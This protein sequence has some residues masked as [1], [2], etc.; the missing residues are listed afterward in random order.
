[1]VLQTWI[2]FSGSRSVRVSEF[3]EPLFYTFLEKWLQIKW[4]I[5]DAEIAHGL[6][7]E[8]L[9]HCTTTIPNSVPSPWD[10]FYGSDGSY[11][12][13]GLLAGRPYFHAGVQPSELDTAFDLGSHTHSTF[14]V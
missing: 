12:I 9:L 11:K 4:L 13:A 8:V 1:M 2:F 10:T 14:L 7:W 5:D 3:E 6:S